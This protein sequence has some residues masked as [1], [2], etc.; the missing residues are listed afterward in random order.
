M[1]KKP[2]NK[3]VVSEIFKVVEE[4]KCTWTVEDQIGLHACRHHG[5]CSATDEDNNGLATSICSLTGTAS[6]LLFKA[7]LT[8]CS[9]T[10]QSNQLFRLHQLQPSPHQQKAVYSTKD[11]L[12]Q[13]PLE[14]PKPK[15]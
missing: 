7:T 13:C 3:I 15:P 10:L 12:A 6:A 2:L 1:H 9:T 11:K 8:I 4:T 14:A 5:C